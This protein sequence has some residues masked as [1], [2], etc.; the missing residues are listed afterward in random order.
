MAKVIP[1]ISH[2][3][4]VKDWGKVAEAVPFMITK[5]TEG[6][7]FVDSTVIA[8]ILQCETRKIPYWLYTYLRKGREKAQTKFMVDFCKNKVGK[9]FQGYIL[10]VEAGNAA[11]D[12]KEALDWLEDQGGKCMIYTMYAEYSKYKA[13]IAGR[14]ENTAWWEARYGKNNGAY[15]SAFPCHAGVDL[16]Q[17]SSQGSCPGIPDK[18]DV[19][20]L[21]G[22]K[23]LDWFTGAKEEKK[24]AV[25][26]KKGY[27]GEFPRIPSRGYFNFGDG[28]T[29]NTAL[30]PDVK[31]LQKLLNWI[32][33]G[34]I[35]VDGM[36]GKN[37]IAAVKL[38]QTN[39]KVK[40]DGL[41]GRE[42][43]KAAKAF[44]K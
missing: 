8:F 34:Q 32:N 21:T 3:H 44:K 42:S 28:W 33:G 1:D 2:H 20:R 29:M 18:I 24:P 10:D 13:V 14:G 5:A 16:H 35:K 15:S 40:C 7:T 27:T 23:G 6:T 4:P 22:T 30:A 36:L 39:M 11:E 19:N 43:L 31:K 38:A 9:Y 12:V 37:T 26:K 17:Y 25:P 41:F